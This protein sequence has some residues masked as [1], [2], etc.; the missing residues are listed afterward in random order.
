MV[1][2]GL[3]SGRSETDRLSPLFLEGVPG[4]LKPAKPAITPREHL[5]PEPQEVHF[6]ASPGPCGNRKGQD[7]GDDAVDQA[8]STVPRSVRRHANMRGL[9]G[10]NE[11]CAKLL[12]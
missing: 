7:R 1:I 11:H 5:T 9:P 8:A 2:P 10:P 3:V 4:D 12:I 6:G